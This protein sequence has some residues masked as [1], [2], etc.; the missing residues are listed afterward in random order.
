MALPGECRLCAADRERLDVITP[1]V[2]G[3]KEGQGFFRCASCN[4]IFAYPPLTPE[5][6][7]SFYTAEFEGFMASRSGAVGGWEKAERHMLANESTR[8][9]RMKYIAPYLSL[10]CNILEVGCSSGF[11]LH[12]LVEAGH[13]CVGVEPSG[14]FS[15]FVSGRG[16]ECYDSMQSLARGTRKFDV[17]MH[18]F[19]LEHIAQPLE[20]L[21]QQ[22]NL[23]AP[24]GVLIF[25]IPNAADPLYS[26]YDIP[27]FERFYWSVAHHWYFSR[28]SVRHLLDKLGLPYEIGLDQRYDLSNHMVWARDGKPGGMGR[29]SAILGKD[30]EEQYK[31]A[32]IKSGHCDTLYAVIRKP[33]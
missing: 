28:D 7:S 33:S 18:F 31:A 27:A 11:M 16:I 32:L 25:E 30:I 20:F 17:A 19:V 10:G 21:R 3:G 29:F 5:E 15:E 1:H 12:P 8:L 6:E 23:L 26:I 2:Y 14:L 13:K 4:V 24:G 22:I 9:R